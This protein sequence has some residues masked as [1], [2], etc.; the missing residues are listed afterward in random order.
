MVTM[1]SVCL[2]IF[3]YQFMKSGMC[4]MAL[5]PISTAYFINPSHQSVCP[6][7]PVVAGQRPGKNI[8]MATNAHTTIKKLLNTFYMQPMLFKR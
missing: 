6:S 7:P 3:L 4:V 8:T 5:E 1:L 2:C